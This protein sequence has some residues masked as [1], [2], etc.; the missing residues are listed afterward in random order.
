MSK[1]GA[2]QSHTRKLERN[3]RL[4]GRALLVLAFAIL[5]LLVLFV[6]GGTLTGASGA[7]LVAVAALLYILGD[8]IV[9]WSQ[10]AFSAAKRA[11]QGANAEEQ[12][13]AILAGLMGEDYFVLHDVPSAAGNVDHIVVARHGG[14]YAIETKSTKGR[15]EA[16][17]DELLLQG[18]PMPGDPIRQ[19]LRNAMWLKQKTGEILGEEPYITAVL[20]FTRARVV[21]K[22]AVRG[23]IIARPQFLHEVLKAPPSSTAQ[24]L[25]IWANR[26]RLQDALLG[27]RGNPAA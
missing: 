3:R 5:V 14:I 25:K 15:V 9:A 7:T 21:S 4:A 20:L 16:S 13:R 11:S 2:E 23:V 17:G 26:V 8:K 24:S 6:V 18:Q 19:T 12:V 1:R 27:S 10:R 22:S